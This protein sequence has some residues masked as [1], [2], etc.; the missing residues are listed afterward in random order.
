[1]KFYSPFQFDFPDYQ[2]SFQL[3]VQM[4][5]PTGICDSLLKVGPIQSP[6]IE[7]SSSEVDLPGDSVGVRI[8]VT[9]G[10]A[11]YQVDVFVGAQQKFI[12]LDDGVS[13]QLDFLQSNDTAY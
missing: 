13:G 12:N 2:D 8:S 4:S 9:H 6:M 11:P 10:T 7:I 3:Y 1:Q 5:K